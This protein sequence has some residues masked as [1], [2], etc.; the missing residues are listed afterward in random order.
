MSLMVAGGHE[1]PGA[2]APRWTVRDQSR[3]LPGGRIE[4]QGRAPD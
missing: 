1:G 4:D 3:D 2:A